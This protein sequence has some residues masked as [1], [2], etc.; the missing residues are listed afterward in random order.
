M[1][2]ENNNKNV[3]PKMREAVL[4]DSTIAGYYYDLTEKD[5]N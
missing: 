4:V 3:C 5:P 1:H 2:L